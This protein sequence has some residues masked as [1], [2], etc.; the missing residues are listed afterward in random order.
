MCVLLSF[1]LFLLAQML[2]IFATSYLESLTTRK[3]T[4]SKRN[5]IDRQ[6]VISEALKYFL[7]ALVMLNVLVI[8]FKTNFY[9][10]RQVIPDAENRGADIY[11]TT[12]L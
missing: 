2:F 9:K 6:R 7:A 11:E 8:F 5:D 4:I 1:L 3:G 10:N 12:I